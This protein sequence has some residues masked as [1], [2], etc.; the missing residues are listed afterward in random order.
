MSPDQS[1]WLLYNW[2]L[3]AALEACLIN[4]PCYPK[5]DF[6]NNV[7][8]PCGLGVIMYLTISASEESIWLHWFGN[9]VFLLSMKD[10]W[11]LYC[12]HDVV[13][14]YINVYSFAIGHRPPRFLWIIQWHHFSFSFSTCQ[15]LCATHEY[16][17]LG[18]LYLISTCEIQIILSHLRDY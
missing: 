8:D 18:R 11:N 2:C 9:N 17:T 1:G 14:K 7:E 3:V 6:H 15:C 13:I 12:L 16:K 5:N 10:L 4:V